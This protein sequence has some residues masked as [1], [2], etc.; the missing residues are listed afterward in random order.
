MGRERGVR[1]R[2]MRD[3]RWERMREVVRGVGEV[4]RMVRARSEVWF[5][6][7]RRVVAC[8]GKAGLL[9]ERRCVVQWFRRWV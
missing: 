8:V 2:G 6:R 4:V 9:V 3:S 1:M 5:R 7:D